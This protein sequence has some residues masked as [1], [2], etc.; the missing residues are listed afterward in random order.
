MTTRQWS[1]ALLF[2]TALAGCASGGAGGG[3]GPATVSR[4]TNVISAEEIAAS[5][6]STALVLVRQL[7]PSWLTSRGVAGLG[8]A[9]EPGAMT[10]SPSDGP[11]GLVVYRDGVRVG[12]FSSLE[13]IPVDVIRE[14]RWINGRDA[15][16][17]F[18]TGHGAGVI[19]VITRR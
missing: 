14:V 9:S 7:R 15:T 13:T 16:Q 18:G 17:R 8:G 4:N 11:A 10:S 12:G 19:E 2:I 1:T 5:S 3:G 6:A